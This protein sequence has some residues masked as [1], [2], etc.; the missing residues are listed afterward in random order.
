VTSGPVPVVVSVDEA[1]ELAQR[2]ELA[3]THGSLLMLDGDQDVSLLDPTILGTEPCLVIGSDVLI[4]SDSDL[5]K[6]LNNFAA[7]PIAALATCILLR[8]STA[9]GPTDARFAFESAVYSSLQ[10]GAEFSRWL[11]VYKPRETAPLES[12]DG[13][14]LLSRLGG[15]LSITLNRPNHGNAVNREMQDRLAEAFRFA[16]LDESIKQLWIDGRGSHFCTGGDLDEFGSFPDPATAHVVRLQRNPARALS[17]LRQQGKR[18]HVDVHGLSAGSGVELAAF[19]SNVRAHKDS[20]F[21]LPE[22]SLGLVPG[23]GG[24]ISIVDRIGSQRTAWLLLTGNRIDAP[25]ALAWGL[26]DEI[27]ANV[28]DVIRQFGF[29]DR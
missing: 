11:S 9:R 8:T 7:A 5:E 3:D 4:A 26:I 15:S 27:E 21:W 6:L 18:V 13:V 1:R 24:S 10:A 28:D 12:P 16:L 29:E 19:A 25:T 23:S 20:T 17:L 22:L 2:A 14:V